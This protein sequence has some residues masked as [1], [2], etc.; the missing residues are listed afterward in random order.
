[1]EF[2]F[3]RI[4]YDMFHTCMI[5]HQIISLNDT[6]RVSEM[7]F[8]IL[9]VFKKSDTALIKAP[10]A[11]CANEIGALL[12]LLKKTLSLITTFLVFLAFLIFDFFA[13][14]MKFWI[15]LVLFFILSFYFRILL[16]LHFLILFSFRFSNI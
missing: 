9:F 1:M 10:M 8:L 5:F 11:Y 7:I 2:H 14:F 12:Y 6:V 4:A 13:F 15:F 16:V 3:Y